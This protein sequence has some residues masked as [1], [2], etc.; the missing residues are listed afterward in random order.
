MW[1]QRVGYLLLA[2]LVVLLTNLSKSLSKVSSYTVSN[3][4]NSG[5]IASRISFPSTLSTEW[6][7]NFLSSIVY[8]DLI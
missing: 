3:V 1:A 4:T 5:Y 7:T 6:F 8:L 2:T